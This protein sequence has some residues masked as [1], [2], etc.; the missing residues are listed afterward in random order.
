MAATIQTVER[1]SESPHLRVG[2][3]LRVL[4]A[5]REILSNLV[6][7]ELKVKYV[8]SVLGAVWSL[9]N[10]LVYL[11][12]F[13]FVT[14]VLGNGLPDYPVY[15]LSGLLAWNL[16][17][18]STLGG[19]RSVIDNAN[20]VKKVAF[21][22][23]I[24]PLAAIGVALVDYG[25][26]LL[27]L[28][29]FIVATVGLHVPD[30]VLL[31]LAFVALLVFTVAL[32]LWVAA[33]NV[34]YRDVGHLLNI[35]MLV[36]FWVTPIVYASGLV[37][38]HLGDRTILKVLYFC[39]PLTAVVEGMHRALYVV[40]TPAGGTSATWVMPLGSLAL[41]LLAVLVASMIFL[42]FTWGSFFARSGDFAEEL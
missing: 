36:W 7:K 14:R 32:T 2:E 27:V 9:L 17:S 38:Q 42:R 28:L 33:V 25:L 19:S 22:R 1:T 21:P 16:F 10:P 13:T 12:V 31:P 41:I 20:L 4:I 34:R 18:A 23:E 3:R 39:N 29:V 8:A 15:L 24:L 35:G 26:Q 5:H 6:R 37:Q 40:E 30:L 11:A